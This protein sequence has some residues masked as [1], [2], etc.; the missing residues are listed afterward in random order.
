TDGTGTAKEALEQVEQKGYA[1][2]YEQNPDDTREV[3]KI[4]AVFDNDLRTIGQ[5]QASD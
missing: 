4:G 3:V 2:K 1:T 5:W